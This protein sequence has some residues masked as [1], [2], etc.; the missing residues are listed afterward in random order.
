MK[1][2][3]TVR[4]LGRRY[5]NLGKFEAGA[6]TA[7]GFWSFLINEKFYF[8]KGYGETIEDASNNAISDLLKHRDGVKNTKI[9]YREV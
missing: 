3:I 5:A 9:I 1:V 6:E 8:G 2:K 4:P 7:F